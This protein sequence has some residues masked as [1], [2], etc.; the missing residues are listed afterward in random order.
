MGAMCVGRRTAA[1]ATIFVVA[2]FAA[3]CGAAGATDRGPAATASFR[4]DF[5]TFRHPAAWRTASY[6]T[7]G[8]LHFHPLIYLSS[9]RTHDPCSQQ[10][11]ETVCGWPVGSLRPGGVLIV[12]E[13]RGFPGWSLAS[14]PGT[15]LRIGGRPGKESVSRPGKCAAIGA[16]ET[17]ELAIKRPLPFNWTAFTACLRAPTAATERQIDTLLASTRF[18]TP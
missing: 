2:A 9:Q 17:I 12:W 15:P 13:N 4:N 10:V 11:S 5:L 1:A 7:V 6:S 16:D 8:A 14:E 3:G 18:L